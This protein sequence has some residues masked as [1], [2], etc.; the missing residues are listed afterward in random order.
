MYILELIVHH[1]IYKKYRSSLRFFS[2]PTSQLLRTHSPKL[3]YTI[4]N[5]VSDLSDTVSYA[6]SNMEP[7][8]HDD[9]LEFIPRASII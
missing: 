2:S 4:S 3:I 1:S 5:K 8:I 9:E 7:Q 6:L